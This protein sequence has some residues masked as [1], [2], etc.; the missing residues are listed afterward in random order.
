M[1][2]LTEAEKRRYR[3]SGYVIPEFR[4]EDG[5]LAAL[6]AAVDRVIAA[7]P[8]ARPEHLVSVH[9]VNNQ[10]EGIRGD[11]AFLDVAMSENILD[12]VEDAIGPNII[13]WGAHL[14]CKPEVT[15]MEVPWH[16]DGEYWPIRPLA[17][18]TVWIAIDD[19]TV[20]NGCMKF[21]AGSH[22]GQTAHSHRSDDREDLVLSR[23]IDSKAYDDGAAVDIEL[24]A[25]QMSLHDVFLVHGSNANRSTRRRA[26]LALRY[27]PASS[28][29][30]RD[31]FPPSEKNGL[32]VD[33]GQRPL[34]L[35]RGGDDKG[36]NDYEI[37]RQWVA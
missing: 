37:G 28:E 11:Q 17:T 33:F 8:D 7:N 15:G 31:L 20:E 1:P 3:E 23:V 6:R 34:F 21:M 36:L 24:E 14:F 4:L 26:G 10:P 13:L 35:L 12:L 22:R 16:Q 2:G 18:V 32:K 5:H 9:V 19:V 25:G 29:F 30:V 27:M